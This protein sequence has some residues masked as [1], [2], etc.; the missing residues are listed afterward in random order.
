M[1]RL[2]LSNA[3][4]KRSFNVSQEETHDVDGINK[5]T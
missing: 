5:K 4:L 3:L 2:F 1:E